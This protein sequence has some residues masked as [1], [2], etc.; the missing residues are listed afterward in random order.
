M[1]ASVKGITEPNKMPPASHQTL[2][3][4]SQAAIE[5]ARPVAASEACITAALR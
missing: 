3:P 5:A 1:T 2:A 4:V